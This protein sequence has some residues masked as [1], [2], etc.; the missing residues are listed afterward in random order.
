MTRRNEAAA[1][2]VLTGP[3]GLFFFASIAVMALPIL[4]ALAYPIG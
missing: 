2:E 1:H 3:A 4:V